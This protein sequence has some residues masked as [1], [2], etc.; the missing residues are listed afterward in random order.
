MTALRIAHV[1]ASKKAYRH[2]RG[3]GSQSA[4]DGS[5]G[6]VVQATVAR[7]PEPIENID[8]FSAK[9]DH[10]RLT[11]QLP[12]DYVY[13]DWQPC[14]PSSPTPDNLSIPAC[15]RRGLS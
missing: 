2:R 12:A 13:S 7:P 3:N 6:T 5:E 1:R 9:N 11:F 4:C 14:L 10:P 8:G 15:L